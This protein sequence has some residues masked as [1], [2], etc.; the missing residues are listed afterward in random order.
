MKAALMRLFVHELP[1]NDKN[2]T[3]TDYYK[4]GH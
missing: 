1:K 2:I 4:F 3:K